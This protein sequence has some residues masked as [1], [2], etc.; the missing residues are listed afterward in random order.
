ME[1]C[2]LGEADTA[3]AEGQLHESGIRPASATPGRKQ[4]QQF[5]RVLQQ[6]AAQAEA[7]VQATGVPAPGAAGGRACQAL[8]AVLQHLQRVGEL[9]GQRP[10]SA[11]AARS[12]AHVSGVCAKLADGPSG[13]AQVLG[14]TVHPGMAATQ[15]KDLGTRPKEMACSKPSPASANQV[16]KRVEVL[17][18]GNTGVDGHDPASLR[19]GSGRMARPG[20]LQPLNTQLGPGVAHA[21][22]AATVPRSPL[23][24]LRNSHADLE[25]SY[26]D[27]DDEGGRAGGPGINIVGDGAGAAPPLSPGPLSPG[28]S[29]AMGDGTSSAMSRALE[30]LADLPPAA[31]AAM[32]RSL[33]MV[34]AGVQVRGRMLCFVDTP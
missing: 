33:D 8:Q 7:E 3:G 17:T 28:M 4:L 21:A 31:A 23:T 25:L 10:T 5:Y 9:T 27:D 32:Y 18:L 22:A 30:E 16:S 29:G 1:G 24:D 20:H 26:D 14:G 19:S 15:D 11:A 13:A 6:V 12:H 2:P 34:A